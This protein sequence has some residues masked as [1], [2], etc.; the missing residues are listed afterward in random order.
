MFPKEPL[1]YKWE[2]ANKSEISKTDLYF[3]SRLETKLL[4]EE[5]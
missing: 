5:C 1:S 2:R 3:S 4:L